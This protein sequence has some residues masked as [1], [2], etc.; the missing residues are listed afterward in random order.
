MDLAELFT[1]LLDTGCR[2]GEAQSLTWEDFVADKIHLEGHIT[3]NSTRR[4]LTATPRVMAA[5]RRMRQKYQDTYPG[6]FSWALPKLA[7]TYRLWRRLQGHLGWMG[8]DCVLYT[9]R[10]TCASRLVQ[11]GI[12]LYRVQIWLGHKVPEMTQRY[13]KFKP[14]HL[15]ELA[16]VLTSGGE[17]VPFLPADAASVVVGRHRVLH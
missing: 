16:R 14:D 4:T 3:K 17:P 9:F 11:R 6:P 10:H 7:V 15:A 1:F 13:A 12:D 5:V 8:K 2:P